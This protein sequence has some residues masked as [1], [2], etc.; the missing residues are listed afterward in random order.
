M[1]EMTALTYAWPA[2][3]TAPRGDGHRVFI[4]PGFMGGDSSTLLLR[5]Y[6]SRLYSAPSPWGLGQN[7]GSFELQDRLQSAFDEFLDLNDGQVSLIGQSLGGVYARMLALRRPERVRQVITL[8]SP[9]ASRG[10]DS[11]NALVSRLF[12]SMSGMSVSEMS[13]QMD[14][15]QNRLPVP[16]TA[17]YSKLDGVVH[18]SACLDDAGE[19]AENVEVLGSH[20]G[21]ALNPTVL[22]VIADRL[23][24][25]LGEWR[26]FKRNGCMRAMVYPKPESRSRQS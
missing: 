20:T 14:E 9:F 10:P 3:V 5:R 1:L 23:A 18:W 22:Y 15:L 4:L 17:V 8:G 21:M 26:P 13:H 2:L 7:S 25:A 6:L 11:V 12:R 16:S 24:Q 19:Q